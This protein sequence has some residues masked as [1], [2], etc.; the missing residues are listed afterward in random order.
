MIS[1]TIRKQDNS[2][3]WVE[4]F[5]TIIDAE[6]W[7]AEEKT[8]PYWQNHNKERWTVTIEDKTH[9]PTPVEI[10]AA[11]ALKTARQARL[12]VLS[13]IGSKTILSNQDMQDA[14]LALIK[15]NIEG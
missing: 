11:E 4:R 15:R 6:K 1:L 3:Y 13:T 5:N 9:V 14:V 10:A 2:I 7:I 12:Q 8:R